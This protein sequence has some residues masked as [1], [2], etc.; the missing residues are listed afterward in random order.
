[1]I[2]EI[3][4][5]RFVLRSLC[6]H[7]ASERYLGWLSDAATARFI[8]S[9]GTAKDLSELKA[10]LRERCERP[11][12]LFLGIFERGSGLHIGNIKYEPID[13]HNRYAVMGILIG[14]AAWRGKGVAGEV[15]ATSAE[16]MRDS[17]G[18]CEI[19]LGVEVDNLAAIAAYENCGFK[20]Q[21]SNRIKIAPGKTVAMVL[22]LPSSSTTG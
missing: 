5:A 11:D 15:I 7:D 21:A 13:V 8:I 6:E 16:W 20:I 14:E 1:M 3:N 10:Y 4:S 9:A 12:I 18:I 2:A 22:G 17:L 19:V